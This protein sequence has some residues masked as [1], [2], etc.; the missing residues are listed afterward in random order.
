MV[1]TNHGLQLHLVGTFGAVRELEVMLSSPL[2]NGDTLCGG[3]LTIRME[4]T[5][6]VKGRSKIRQGLAW[7][8]TDEEGRRKNMKRMAVDF[9]NGIIY[10]HLEMDDNHYGVP[11]WD[12][13]WTPDMMGQTLKLREE[14]RGWGE[15]TAME[16]WLTPQ[17]GEVYY[18]TSD[19]GEAAN[20]DYYVCEY[21]RRFD[22]CEL[23]LS[24]TMPW[25]KDDWHR[26]LEERYLECTRRD[27][28][29]II[30]IARPQ[31][32]RVVYQWN[33]EDPEY[34]YIAIYLTLPGKKLR[35]WTERASTLQSRVE[36]MIRNVTGLLS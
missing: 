1:W 26:N 8:L 36:V 22:R 35:E 23:E 17:G 29:G 15:W 21:P 30:G 7:K 20:N 16:T 27:G 28:T 5:P 14:T 9:R 12:L 10:F 19:G 32:G 33:Q 18:L 13:L 24:D 31:G 25:G 34:G 4:E 2:E 11:T 6:Y 3:T